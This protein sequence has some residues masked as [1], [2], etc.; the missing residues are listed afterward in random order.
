MTIAASLKNTARRLLGEQGYGALNDLY[1]RLQQGSDDRYTESVR[2]MAALKDKHRGERCFIIGNGPSLKN[3]DLSFLKDEATFGLNRIYLMFQELGFATT[4]LVAVNLLVI[5]QC[6][7]EIAAL[8]CPKFVSWQ[9]RDLIDFTGDMMFLCSRGRPR[10]HTD[11]TGGVWEGATVTF[12]AMQIAYYLGFK[13]AILIGVDHSFTTKGEPHKTVVTQDSDPNH[14]S[15]QYF[16][17]GF[18]W[19]L[20][21]LE[22][23]EQAYRMAKRQ[24]EADGREILDA[25]VG[26]QL[27]VFPKVDYRAL[28]A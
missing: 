4:Y 3:T 17:K 23:S 8:D 24:F 25:T 28:F 9:G 12:V 5:E 10:F 13:Q 27:Q 22:R 26:G 1:L 16:G 20:P 21:D 14:F 2:R 11:I 6:A 18:R 15:P 19:Q 7:A